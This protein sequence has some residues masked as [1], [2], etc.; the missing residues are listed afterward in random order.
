MAAAFFVEKPLKRK[1]IEIILGKFSKL[2]GKFF[3][4]RLKLFLLQNAY[5]TIFINGNPMI[6]IFSIE[7]MHGVV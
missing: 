1:I 4:S 7:P 5:H 6:S 2:L 3:V